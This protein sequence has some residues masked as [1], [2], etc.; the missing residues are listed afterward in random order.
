VSF[1]SNMDDIIT[2]LGGRAQIKIVF[3]QDDICSSCPG[4]NNVCS[5]SFAVKA[6]AAVAAL[7]GLESGTIVD[8]RETAERLREIMTAER[9]QKICAECVWMKKGVCCDTFDK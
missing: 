5:E 1:T 7:L 9:H 3:S 4:V 8:Y 2:R 6:D